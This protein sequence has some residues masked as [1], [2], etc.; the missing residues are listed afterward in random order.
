[1]VRRHEYDIPLYALYNGY[2]FARYVTAKEIQV[3]I[4]GTNETVIIP[5]GFPTDGRSSG[6]FGFF[7]PRWGKSGRASLV[8]DYLYKKRHNRK[9]ADKI[10]LD[11]MNELNPSECRSTSLLSLS[12]NKRVWPKVENYL[13]Y[14]YVRLFGWMLYLKK[15]K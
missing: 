9:E 7:I 5:E 10:F 3:D 13:S 8:H 12:L 1:M 6:L 4:P 11:L 14:Y 15:P 2:G